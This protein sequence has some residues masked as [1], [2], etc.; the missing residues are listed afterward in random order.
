MDLNSVVS[1]AHVSPTVIDHKSEYNAI[2]SIFDYRRAYHGFH[3]SFRVS[4]DPVQ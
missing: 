4:N 1:S 2:V 3:C